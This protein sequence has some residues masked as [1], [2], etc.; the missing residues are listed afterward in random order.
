MITA[1]SLGIRGTALIFLNRPRVVA[2]F[3]GLM[4]MWAW[5]GKTEEACSQIRERWR[6]KRESLNKP[7]GHDLRPDRRDLPL[8][9]QRPAPGTAWPRRAQ[10]RPDAAGRPPL[11]HRKRSLR[12]RPGGPK[13]AAETALSDA[14]AG[15]VAGRP[16]YPFRRRNQHLLDRP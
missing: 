8:P 12:L 13:V 15:G 7:H 4:Q 9:R 3:S 14:D 10:A 11:R 5:R 6:K 1:S 2:L 16:E